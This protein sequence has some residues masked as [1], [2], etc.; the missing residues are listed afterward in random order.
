MKKQWVRLLYVLGLGV[1]LLLMFKVG[2]FVKFLFVKIFD[3]SYDSLSAQIAG[4]I[5]HAAVFIVVIGVGLKD[6]RKTLA[7]V[8]S[9]KKVSGLVWGVAIICS[10][11]Y[12]LFGFYLHFL[13]FSFLY[14]WDT[15]LGITEGNFFINLIDSAIIP[16]VAEEMLFKG[17]VFTILKKHYPTIAAVIIASLLFAVLHL[18]PIRIIPLFLLSC[19]TF[20]IYLRS[21]SLIL[22]MLLHFTNNLFADVLIS[23]PFSSLG[24]F[25]AALVLLG[26]GSYMMYKL[27]KAEKEK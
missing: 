17:I 5:T 6:Q 20:W 19:Y 26:I 7:S 13:F 22:P 10:I 23:E 3:L 24:T 2:N 11:G 15:Y 27:S 21:G 8:C 25:Y 14:G 12:T 16:A 9:F 1:L 18:D 4:I